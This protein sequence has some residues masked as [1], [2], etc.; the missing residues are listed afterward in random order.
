M[1]EAAKV[2]NRMGFTE[3]IRFRLG[4]LRHAHRL[5]RELRAVRE[6]NRRRERRNAKLKAELARKNLR[7]LRAEARTADPARLV[8]IFGTGR[9]GS[10]WLMRMMGET[11]ATW[12]E[13]LVGRLFGDFLNATTDHQRRGSA[14]ILGGGYDKRALRQFVLWS[15][16]Q[17]FPDA[18]GIV[19]KEPHGSVGAPY[20]SAALPESSFICLVRD[21]R[22]VVASSLDAARPDAWATRKRKRMGLPPQD[23]DDMVRVGAER[24]LK[25]MGASVATYGTHRGPKAMVRYEALRADTHGQVRDLYGALRLT[26]NEGTLR[27][28]VE[29]Q[30]WE[31]VPEEKKGPGRTRRKATPGG[32]REDLTEEQAREVERIT[33]PLMDELGYERLLT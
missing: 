14:F 5:H 2:L 20:L 3:E 29:K 26:V 19:I 23:P 31:N 32:W 15:A 18:D 28:A 30:A 9:V 10:T 6:E 21:P 11:H 1:S 33:A 17:R 16:G 24:Y 27:T 7:G 13:P 4:C 12:N 25:L 8:W 22:D